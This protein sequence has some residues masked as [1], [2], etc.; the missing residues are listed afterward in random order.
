MS[1]AEA[2]RLLRHYEPD[3]VADLLAFLL[4]VL[5]SNA[6]D[7]DASLWRQ[8]VAT[9][10]EQCIPLPVLRKPPRSDRQWMRRALRSL[11]NA[12]DDTDWCTLFGFHAVLSVVGNGMS[13]TCSP[14]PRGWA[15]T[16][17]VCRE[18]T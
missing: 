15:K 8:A 17:A 3:N 2:V 18:A 7:D 1:C 11:P 13:A 12:Q 16:R 6:E 10:T 5:R 14:Q 9:A 4:S